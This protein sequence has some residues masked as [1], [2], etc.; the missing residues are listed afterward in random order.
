MGLTVFNFHENILK[1]TVT[2]Y[3]HNFT[4]EYFDVRKQEEHKFNR[5]S[6]ISSSYITLWKKSLYS[7]YFSCFTLVLKIVFS[8][9]IW[10]LGT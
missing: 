10:K 4:K 9:C 5:K 1:V 6:L 2:F 3:Q 7:F 8:Y